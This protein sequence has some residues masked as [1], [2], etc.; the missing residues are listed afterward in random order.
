MSAN[1]LKLEQIIS[2]GEIPSLLLAYN[3]SR[4]ILDTVSSAEQRLE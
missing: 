3:N 1:N 4:V 2:E